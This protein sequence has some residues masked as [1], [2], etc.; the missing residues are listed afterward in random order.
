MFKNGLTINV[1]ANQIPF[2]VEASNELIKVGYDCDFGQ[3]NSFGF[4]LVELA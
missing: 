2:R 3:Q 1:K 4:G